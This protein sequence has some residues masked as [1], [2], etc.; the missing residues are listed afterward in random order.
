MLSE[1]ITPR[2]DPQW[3]ISKHWTSWGQFHREPAITDMCSVEVHLKL[4][5]GSATSSLYPVQPIA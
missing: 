4:V 3:E 2:I 5:V 1:I